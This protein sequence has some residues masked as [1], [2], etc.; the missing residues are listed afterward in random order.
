LV[1]DLLTRHTSGRD[2]QCDTCTKLWR[3]YG[4]AIFR[5]I[6]PDGDQKL[7]AMQHDENAVS[8][9]PQ[10]EAAAAAHFNAR[11]AIRQHEVEA[12]PSTA[13]TTSQNRA[14]RP[15]E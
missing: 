12:H 1:T 7:A 11:E 2:P 6:R 5:H 14:T 8:L 13:P 4:K 10:V 3:D 9:L 15:S